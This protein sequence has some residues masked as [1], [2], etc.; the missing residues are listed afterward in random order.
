MWLD[1]IDYNVFMY[2]KLEDVKLHLT[3]TFKCK[4]KSKV[5][6]AYIKGVFH[7]ER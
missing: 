4:F 6:L 3:E 1:V 7:L 5:T 2:P